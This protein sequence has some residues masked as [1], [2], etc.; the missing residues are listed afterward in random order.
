M[1]SWVSTSHEF[2]GTNSNNI[3]GVTQTSSSTISSMIGSLFTHI[4]IAVLVLCVLIVVVTKGF[5]VN[6]WRTITWA[7]TTSKQP[8]DT[9]DIDVT[10]ALPPTETTT[11][12]KTSKQPSAV[13]GNKSPL[14][15]IGPQPTKKQVFHIPGNNYTYT[16]ARALCKAYG[17]ELATYEQIEDAYN[18]G[19]NFCS[20]GWSE[21]QMGFFPTQKETWDTLQNIP[22]HENDCGR[23]GVNGGKM[24][25]PSIL[26]GVNCYGEKP[27]IN[28]VEKI[29]METQPIYPLSEEQ[30]EINKKV[31]DYQKKLKTTLISPFNG[32]QW[33]E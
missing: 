4:L 11:S 24:L 19:A 14:S 25:N 12:K 13:A 1:G 22:G 23:I 20:Y 3:P 5:G 8:P 16:D 21:D 30:L 15:P 2:S 32:T 27:R 7:G 17:A 26:L 18:K 6:V 33:S 9:T 28:T 29:L 31:Q 10:V